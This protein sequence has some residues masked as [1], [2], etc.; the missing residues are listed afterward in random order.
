MRVA[1]RTLNKSFGV[2]EEDDILAETL[3]RD[4]GLSDVFY[5]HGMVGLMVALYL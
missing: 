1:A 4:S 3:G 5:S 2:K